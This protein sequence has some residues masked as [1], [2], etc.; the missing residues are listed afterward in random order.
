MAES[1]NTKKIAITLL[2]FFITSSDGIEWTKAM[3][4]VGTGIKLRLGKEK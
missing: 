1:T 3:M 4:T 2:F